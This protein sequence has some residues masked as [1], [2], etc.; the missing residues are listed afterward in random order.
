MRGCMNRK[1]LRLFTGALLLALMTTTPGLSAPPTPTAQCAGEWDSDGG[2]HERGEHYQTTSGGQLYNCVACG[3]CTPAGSGGGGSSGMSGGLPTSE[4]FAQ[5][6]MM[7]IIGNLIQQAFAPPPDNSAYLQQQAAMEKAKK[8]AEQRER[9]ARW[10]QLEQIRADQQNKENS[11]LRSMLDVPSLDEPAGGSAFDVMDWGDRADELPARGGG[12]YDTAGLSLVQRLACA[13]DLAQRAQQA[14]ENGDYINAR[15][16]NEQAQNAMS[17]LP[18]ELECRYDDAPAMPQ[19]ASA[20]TPEMAS[21][22]A[23]IGQVQR[24][25][26][27]LQDI[28]L[29]RVGIEQ[30]KQAAIAQIDKAR[31]DINTIKSQPSNGDDTLLLEAEQLL[32]QAEND[33][34]ALEADEQS[35]AQQ[36]TDIEN[37]LKAVQEQF[38]PGATDQ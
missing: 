37:S 18:T 9:M 14:S 6:M 4:E 7:G 5:Q 17:G 12:L 25:V 13:N 35:L 36:Q 11:Q 23:I 19:S 21:Y 1:T 26:Q 29:R 33:L 24:D 38:Q 22:Q 10:Q 28:K 32:A 20:V 15:Y 16:L 30:E 31:E 8:E 27:R 2:F 3:G 34:A